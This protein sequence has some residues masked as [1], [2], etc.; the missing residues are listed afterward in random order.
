VQALG[1][2]FTVST[3][4]LALALQHAGEI[5]AALLWPSL[6]ALAMVLIGMWA[7]KLVRGRIE[8]ETFRLYFFLGLLALGGHLALRGVL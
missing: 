4:T 6:L 2:S 5:N 7:G 3:V 1:L 8:P